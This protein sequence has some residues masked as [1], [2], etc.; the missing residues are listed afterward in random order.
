MHHTL[1]R[2]AMLLAATALAATG[3]ASCSPRG[4]D[5]PEL[6]AL[7][8]R[9]YRLGPNDQLRVITFGEDGLSEVFRVSDAGDIAVP[10]I[11]NVRADGL[12]TDE[13]SRRITDLLKSK[14]L[15]RAPSVSVEITEYR[16]LY[17]IGEV[18]RPGLV[19]YQPG[20][21][22]L[23]AIAIAGGYTYRAVEDYASITRTIAGVAIKGKVLP[24]TPVAPGDVITVFERY[25]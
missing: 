10:L 25:F 17:V 8:T 9:A 12:T 19:T 15:L 4:S 13:L 24:V 23:A 21:T 14:N 7:Q 5:L 6:P 11:G 2:R 18:V 3:L 1:S 16:P 20:M 22:T